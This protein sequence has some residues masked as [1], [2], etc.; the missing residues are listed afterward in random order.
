MKR[1]E[2]RLDPLVRYRQYRERLALMEVARAKESL[3]QTKRKIQQIEQTRKDVSMDLD[4][5][6]TEGIGMEYFRLYA[7]YLGGL[8]RQMES[9]QELLVEIGKT[10]R[11]T[12]KAAEAE[13]VRKKTLEWIKQTEYTRYLQMLGR[14]EQKEA[15]EIITLRQRFG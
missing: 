5:Q 1:F 6:Q 9:E 14:A 7:A 12:Q 10:I 15:D 2:F 8:H 4:K 3:V 11:E 13:T